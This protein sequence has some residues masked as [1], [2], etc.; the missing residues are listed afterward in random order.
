MANISLSNKSRKRG[1]KPSLCAGDKLFI[2]RKYI[3]ARSAIEAIRKDKL[4]P[5]DDVWIDEDFR[6]SSPGA[7][8]IGFVDYRQEE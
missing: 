8:A 2:V 4:T 7:S 3:L 5:V 6:K 1:P